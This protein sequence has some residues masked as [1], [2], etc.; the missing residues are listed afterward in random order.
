VPNKG[1]HAPV[2]KRRRASSPQKKNSP[3]AEVIAR[4]GVGAAGKLKSGAIAFRGGGGTSEAALEIGQ[5]RN[6]KSKPWV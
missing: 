2:R 6:G 1:S 4:K 3:Q 5:I